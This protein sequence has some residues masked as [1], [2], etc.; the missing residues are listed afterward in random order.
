M[1]NFHTH[2]KRC[3]HAVG[4]EEDYVVSAIRA[5]YKRLGFSEHMP[6]PPKDEEW[7]YRLSPFEV[8]DYVNEVLRLKEKYK[9]EIEIF[10]SFEFEYFNNRIEWVDYL[11]EKYPL[12]YT[13][14]GNHFYKRVSENTYFGRFDKKT[15]IEKYFIAQKIERVKEL[16]CYDELSLSEIAFKLNYSSVAHLSGQF[17]RVTG[18]TPSQFKQKGGLERRPIDK[19]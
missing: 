5:G 17:K 13:I 2:T 15:T 19:V 12:D 4:V 7:S 6:L 18:L 16:L 9:D 11:I 14:G 8:D 3:N 10:L 1:N